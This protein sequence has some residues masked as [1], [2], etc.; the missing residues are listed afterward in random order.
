MA[1]ILILN[2]EQEL[3]V[4]EQTQ[5]LNCQL[6]DLRLILNLINDLL[7]AMSPNLINTSLDEH[8]PASL[9]THQFEHDSLLEVALALL[10]ED[11]DEVIGK[12][13]RHQTVEAVLVQDEVGKKDQNKGLGGVVVEDVLEEFTALR[14]FN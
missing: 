7:H 5:V 13:V 6:H 9:I 14:G 1:S 8:Q 11:L 2:N 3:I 4:F 10:N 12:F